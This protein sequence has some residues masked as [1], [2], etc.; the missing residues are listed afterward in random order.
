M[1]TDP[2]GEGNRAFAR[3]LDLTEDYLRDEYRSAPRTYHFTAACPLNMEAAP[4]L[5]PPEDAAQAIAE[6]VRVCQACGLHTG[7]THAVPGEGADHPLVMVVGEG[8]GADEDRTGRPF[9]GPAG[10][11]LDKMLAAVGLYRARNC[12]IANVV[13][14]R[15]PGNRDPLPEETAACAPFLARQ[16]ALLHPRLIL[17][18]GRVPTQTLLKTEAPIGKLR[19]RF[20]DY[21]PPQHGARVLD[22]NDAIPLLPTYHP[23]ALLRD[24]SYKAPA[25][26]DLKLL[27]ARLAA[28]DPAYAEETAEL[29]RARNIAPYHEK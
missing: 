22:G 8:P 20:V 16:F 7:R 9:V 21:T 5:V 24:D 10:Q 19:G 4:A 26:E 28:L 29:R 1:N 25:W 13:K 23:S 3:F 14:C 18:V 2:A 11:L 6:A 17:S 15:P 12:F 27:C